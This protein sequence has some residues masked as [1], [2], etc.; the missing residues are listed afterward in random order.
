MNAI[1][2]SEIKAGILRI[3]IV[4]NGKSVVWLPGIS[5]QL[6]SALTRIGAGLAL[7]IASF[8]SKNPDLKRVLAI[9]REFELQEVFETLRRMEPFEIVNIEDKEKN[10]TVLIR[11][12]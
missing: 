10:T 4:E 3:R 7:K 9:L 12:E 1:P 5:L 2:K 6:L 11:T 8:D